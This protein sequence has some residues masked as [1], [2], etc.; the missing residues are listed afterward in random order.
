M[1][2]VVANGVSRPPLTCTVKLED[3]AEHTVKMSYGLHQDL[4]RLIPDPLAIAQILT[5]DPVTRDYLIRR[6]MTE[7]KKIIT[8]FDELK[9]AEDIGLDDPDEVDK[10]LQWVVGHILYFFATSAGGITRLA[11]HFKAALKP[12]QLAPSTD[13]SPT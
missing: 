11:E 1:T 5:A 2:A 10:L 7:T 13:G 12:D 6:C 9:P 3:G 4:Q 8:N